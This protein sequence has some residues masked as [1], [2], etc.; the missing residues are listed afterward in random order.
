MKFSQFLVILNCYIGQEKSQLDFMY[1][2]FQRVMVPPFTEEDSAL[3]ENDNY[4]PFSKKSDESTAK[5]VY[6]G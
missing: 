5:K 6:S 1:L 3:E 2:C 4:Y